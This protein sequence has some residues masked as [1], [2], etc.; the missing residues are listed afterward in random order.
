MDEDDA[1]LV[2]RLRHQA[3][4]HA[5]NSTT[6]MLREEAAD[7]IERLHRNLNSRDEF[8]VG[9]RVKGNE[10]RRLQTR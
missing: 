6:Q 7:A 10:H 2:E 8:L 1:G 5:R 9:K 3:P 4:V